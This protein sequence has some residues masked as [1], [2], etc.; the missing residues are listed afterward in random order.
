MSDRNEKTTAILKIRAKLLDA[1]RCWLKQNNYVEVH[2]PTII[3]AVG[4]WPGHFEVKYFDKK[5]Y[6]AQGLQPYAAAFVAK[7]GKIYTIA[8]TFRAEKSNDGRHLTEY[9]RIEVAQQCGL[10]TLIRSKEELVTHVC[11]ALA[12][13]SLETFK[14]LNRSAKDF[15]KLRSPFPRLT[16]DEAVDILQRDGFNIVWGQKLDWD[17]ESHLSGKFNQPFFIV[18]FPT[19]IETYF[20]E[21]DPKR[22]ELTLSAD[23]LAPDGYGELG[24]S[25][26]IIAEKKVMIKKMAEQ[27]IDSIDQG[28]YMHFMQSGV[29]SLSEF[30]IGLERLMQWICKLTDIREAVAF[31]RLYH[32]NYP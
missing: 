18:K 14:S 3:P 7:L 28:W 19:N 11:H 30:A 15:T 12:K 20:Y 29:S 24:S 21:S 8:P 1:A 9:W 26:Q 23:L 31:P 22:P 32:E 17:L 25:A 13:E 5:A 27:N 2:G 10:D 16:Y 6:L 4:D